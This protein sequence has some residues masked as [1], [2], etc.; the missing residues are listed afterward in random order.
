MKL[1]LKEA[2]LF[3]LLGDLMFA[4]KLLMEVF[5]NMHLLGVLIVVYTV[6][7]RQ[8]AL[9][10]IGVFVV[11][12]GL[13]Y[14]FST[15]WIPYLYIW[16]VLWGLVMLIPRKLP[17]YWYYILCV[18]ACGLHGFLYGTLYAPAQALLFGLSFE[19][20]LA[21]IVA[22]F[23][24]DVIHGVSNFFVSI[25]IMPFINILQRVSSFHRKKT[26]TTYYYH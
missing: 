5:P 15:W 25:L 8:K 17:T 10:P 14:G 13:F 12:S 20:M 24:F 18:I 19:G 23:P 4:S 6:T 2:I 16:A 21:W 26:P 9:Y 11:L 22:G 7:F 3:A 1:S